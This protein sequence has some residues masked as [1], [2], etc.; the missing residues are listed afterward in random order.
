[1]ENFIKS[2]AFDSFPANRRQM[3]MVYAQIMDRTAQK[4]KMNL[5]DR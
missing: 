4:K 3:M 2:G 1:M 5:S